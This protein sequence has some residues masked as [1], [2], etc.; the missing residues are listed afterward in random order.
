[1]AIVWSIC[2]AATLFITSQADP[3][4]T[5]NSHSGSV[6]A[7]VCV[8]DGTGCFD[9]GCN[10]EQRQSNCA[11]FEQESSCKSDTGADNR[12]TWS[13]V[14]D[15][16][17]DAI[18]AEVEVA[19]DAYGNGCGFGNPNPCPDSL[20]QVVDIQSEASGLCV[21]DGTG[22]FNDGCDV[23]QRHSNCAKFEMEESCRS[24]LGADN[25]CIWSAEGSA[26]ESLLFGVIDFDIGSLSSLNPMH[27]T[28]DMI[29]VVA[30][31]FVFM[32]WAGYSAV[33]W[34]TAPPKFEF[35]EPIDDISV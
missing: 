31:V 21:W 9:N 26:K 33:Q 34:F 3:P 19:S 2:I 24:E 30:A 22:C 5:V 13:A 28:W 11:K 4:A 16:A 29:V 27:M 25:R 18:G 1:M 7:Y 10:P 15:L 17:A 32:A 20:E 8:W 12:C 6:K 14:A 35:Y 23:E